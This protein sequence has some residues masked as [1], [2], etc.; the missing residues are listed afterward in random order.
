MISFDLGS[1]TNSMP[2]RPERIPPDTKTLEI[3]PPWT[4]QPPRPSSCGWSS[5]ASPRRR[6]PRP[7][8]RSGPFSF[9]RRGAAREDGGSSA[10]PPLLLIRPGEHAAEVQPVQGAGPVDGQG[11]AVFL[12]FMVEYDNH[13]QVARRCRTYH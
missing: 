5:W 9:R 2:A 6:P 4:P 11:F 7:R 13:H 1:D 8:A 10:Q 12:I 3:T